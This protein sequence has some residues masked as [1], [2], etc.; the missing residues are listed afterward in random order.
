M[1]VCVS[2]SAQRPFA[3]RENDY[4]VGDHKCGGNAQGISR[5]RFVHHTSFLWDFSDANMALLRMPAKVP[6]YRSQR[7][8]TDFL[9]KLKD[10]LPSQGP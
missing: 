10:N 3:L 6:D 7:A 4:V 5:D 8:H 9:C 2:S 1:C